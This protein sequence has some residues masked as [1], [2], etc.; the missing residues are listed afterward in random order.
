M[1]TI[2]LPFDYQPRPYQLPFFR[3]MDSGKLRAILRWHRRGGKDLTCIHFTA[4]K[5]FERVGNYYHVLP[6]YAQ[7]RKAVWDGKDKAG[8][9]FISAF[10]DEII[11]KKNDQ[12][13][14]LTL[15]NGS[16]WQLIGADNIDTIV[17][18]NPVGIV[19]SEYSLMRPEAWDLMRPILAENGGWTVFNF[20]PRG[21]N[22]AFDLEQVALDAPDRWFV[23]VRRA[24]ETGVF[25]KETLDAELSEIV[26]KT[27]DDALFR[28]EY[29]VE[30]LS[31]VQGAYFAR[32]MDAIPLQ[33]VPY[34]PQ[35]PVHDV[36]D[37]G[38]SDSTAVTLWQA[39]GAQ[40]RLIETVEYTGKGLPEIIADLKK[41]PYV[42]G[43]HF[44]PHDIKVRELGTGQSRL[45]VANALGWSFEVVPSVPLQDGI[46]NCRAKLSRVVYD[47]DRAK[48]WARAMRQYQRKYDDR[49]HSFTDKPLHDWTSHYADS[50]RYAA[51]VFDEMSNDKEKSEEAAKIIATNYALDT[52]LPTIQ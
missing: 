48:D 42:W 45:E 14:K 18:T 33:T 5:S 23:D 34:D 29:L 7:A 35:M 13:M 6:F 25:T 36:W 17:G 38:V 20:T 50:T 2:T 32:Q 11:E 51:L 9:P 27:G 28:Q 15:K 40:R 16:I 41:R 1:T 49:T 8:K 43:K 39:V 21:Q 22:H 10:P 4:K 37:L 3:A 30:Y 52:G 26:S 47:K 24:D 31:A 19:F 46:D 44:A 12:E